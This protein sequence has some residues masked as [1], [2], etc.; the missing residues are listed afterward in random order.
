MCTVH[1]CKWLFSLVWIL[2]FNILSCCIYIRSSI[3][4]SAYSERNS[5]EFSRCPFSKPIQFFFLFWVI[6][7]IVKG[8]HFP[9]DLICFF[10]FLP[11]FDLGQMLVLSICAGSIETCRDLE[12]KGVAT[13]AILLGHT[14]IVRCAR[15]ISRAEHG[16]TSIRW[17][18]NLIY[19]YLDYNNI[20]FSI[21]K[22]QRRW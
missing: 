22:K 17:K 11:F 15:S 6:N 1:G 10:S 4:W 8:N 9:C 14:S 2:K 18:Q 20:C 7:N 3:P 19:F 5:K 13:A 12:P 21:P 16:N